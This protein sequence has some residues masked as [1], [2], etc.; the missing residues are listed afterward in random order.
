[1][2]IS[3]DWLQAFFDSPLPDAAELERA[4]TFHAFEIEGIEER[5][6]D[7]VL[8]VKITANRGHDC[9]SHRGIARELSAIL[10]LPLKGDPLRVEV[11]LT[12]KTDLVDIAID[13]PALC[14]R[15]I[16]GYIRGVHVKPSPSWLADRLEAIGQRPINNVVDATNYV[17]FHLGQPL[18]AFDAGRLV[19]KD[20]RY[21]IRVRRAQDGEKMVALDEKEYT[22]NSSMLL[23]GDDHARVPAGI[24]GVK[25]GAPAAISDST[26]DI[27]IESANFDGVSVRKTAQALKLRTDA[28]ARFEQV[29]S[30]E[31]AAYGMHMAAQLILELAGGE[32]VGFNDLYVASAEEM[33]ASVSKNDIN[34][35]LGTD[36]T[37]AAIA[38]SLARLDLSFAQAQDSFVVTAPIERLDLRESVD[39]IEEVARTHGYD[40]IP[41]VE[42]PALDRSADVNPN[43][44]WQERVREF[45]VERGFSEVYTP[46]FAENGERVVLN[47]VDGVK[48]YLRANLTDGLREALER[49]AR[50]RDLI[51]FRQV[52]IF[53]IGTVW[54]DGEEK[55]EVE[56]AVEKMK[57][58]KTE[59]EYRAELQAFMDSLDPMPSAYTPLPGSTAERYQAF[60]RYPFIVRDISMWIDD[61]DDARGAVLNIFASS[62][63][64]LLRHVNL[65]DQFK[66]DGRT[67]LGFRLVFQSY[68]MTL[69][70]EIVNGV[71]ESITTAIRERGWEVR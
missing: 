48:P 59:E 45:L 63:Q 71:M 31:V 22:L 68:E 33:N 14:S 61:S 24:A 13:E 21:A 67:S 40:H 36:F 50:N 62:S 46:V 3:R 10:R 23:I 53:E 20:G 37:D 39:L 35:T 27:I 57:K 55:V 47:K 38:D 19:Q 28:S 32:I 41:S 58:E 64:G 16:A 34:E 26:S 43:F 6:S 9:L 15:Y 18:H 70:D 49:N 8:D 2:K 11:S 5:G 60:S 12:P 51:G 17:M 42:L 4:L 54:K 29:I 66:K 69:T 25:G 44:E 7:S 30:P 65:F 56:I 52:K 1:M